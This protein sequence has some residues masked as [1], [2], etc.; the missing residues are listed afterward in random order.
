M[1]TR[2][3]REHLQGACDRALEYYDAGQNNQA[4]AK[5]LSDV[6]KHE[7]TRKIATHPHAYPLLLLEVERSRDAFKEAML[8]WSVRG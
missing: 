1:G 4:I 6:R 2:T 8:G 7:G 3:A 5:F